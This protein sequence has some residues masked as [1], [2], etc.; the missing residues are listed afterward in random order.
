MYVHSAAC[1]EIKQHI[2]KR[3]DVTD[4]TIPLSEMKN[5]LIAT[6]GGAVTRPCNYDIIHQNATVVFI[7]RAIQNL[8]TDGRPLSQGG[9][10]RLEKMYSE[11]YPLYK[12]F[13]D[14]SVES[15]NT[16]Q[17]TSTLIKEKLNKR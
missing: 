4:H 12:K 6:G 1:L 14:F 15:Q 17:E 11:R 9:V 2:I 10:E 3:D 13:C 8:A 5:V 16:W 7:E